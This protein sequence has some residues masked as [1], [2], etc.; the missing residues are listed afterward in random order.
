MQQR[1]IKVSKSESKKN[2]N[3]LE[4]SRSQKRKNTDAAM[5]FFYNSKEFLNVS[6]RDNRIASIVKSAPQAVMVAHLTDALQIFVVFPSSDWRG[7]EK[8]SCFSLFFD[9]LNAF[10]AFDWSKRFS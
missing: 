3:L 5:L 9:R 1:S 7:S 6:Q 2:W 10:E 8:F 4:I